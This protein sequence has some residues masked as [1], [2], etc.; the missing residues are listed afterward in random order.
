M[1]QADVE[2]NPSKR[3]N[4]YNQAEQLLVTNVAWIPLDQGV[5]TYLLR[6]NVVNYQESAV[7]GP[8]IDT[9][10]HVYLGKL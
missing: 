3:M 2:L 6:P 10:Q 8:S 5:G 4:A 1:R 7:G 9:W